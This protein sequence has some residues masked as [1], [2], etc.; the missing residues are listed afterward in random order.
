M[1]SQYSN[2]GDALLA[3]LLTE[4]LATKTVQP[5]QTQEPTETVNPWKK[6]TSAKQPVP[7]NQPSTVKKTASQEDKSQS[8]KDEIVRL[9]Q[10]ILKAKDK[11]EKKEVKEDEA[12]DDEDDFS[13]DEETFCAKHQNRQTHQDHQV[14]RTFKSCEEHRGLKPVDKPSGK[15][16]NIYGTCLKGSIKVGLNLK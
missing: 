13:S 15:T 4:V 12:T 2:E 3:K 10:E 8:D 6:P 16:V 14:Q 9:C 5:S 1:S 11:E 7:S